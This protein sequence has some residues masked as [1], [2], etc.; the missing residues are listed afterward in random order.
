MIRVRRLTREAGNLRD[1]DATGRRPA[2]VAPGAE[3]GCS[4]LRYFFAAQ[5]F[6]A[7]SLFLAI[8]PPITLTIS[9]VALPSV[10]L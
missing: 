5:G 9:A 3:I 6:F 4:S 2:G 10:S 1:E 8:P 7:A